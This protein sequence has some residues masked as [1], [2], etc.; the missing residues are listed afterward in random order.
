MLTK[1]VTAAVA[2]TLPVMTLTNLAAQEVVHAT[3]GTVV[4]IDLATSALTLQKPDHSTEVFQLTQSLSKP[5]SFDK[6]LREESEAADKLSKEQTNIIVY[7]FGESPETV[8][9]VKDLGKEVLD[10]S[11]TVQQ[12]DKGQH[13]ITIRADSGTQTTCY[14][15]KDASV[16]TLFGVVEG[17]KYSPKKGEKIRMV[18]TQA[19][20]KETAEFIQTL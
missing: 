3:A 16:E 8:V 17:G 2:V 11:G 14:T 5:V 4:K 10:V 20:G 19:A 1:L 13:A 18:C 9:S 7:Y 6:S 12:V 15:A